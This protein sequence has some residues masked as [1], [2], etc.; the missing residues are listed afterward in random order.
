MSLFFAP[1]VRYSQIMLENRRFNLPHLYLA[2]LLGVTALEFRRD[3]WHQKTRR[4]ALLYGI[5]SIAGRF[6]GL[7]TNHV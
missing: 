3:L 5:K 6:F 7:V 2:P 4:I 1:F